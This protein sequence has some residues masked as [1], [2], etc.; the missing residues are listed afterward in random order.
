[1]NLV[2]DTIAAISTPPGEGGIGI[3]RLSG[4]QAIEWVEKIFKSTTGKKLSDKTR[5]VYYG[6]IWD[7]HECI[8]EVL[9][10]VMRA[11]HSYTAEDVVEIN[12][13]GGSGPLNAMLETVLKQG[14]RLANP[15]EF[16][17]RAFLNGRIDLIQAEAV[18][19]RIQARTRAGLKAAASSATGQLS[20]ALFD[21]KEQLL[22]AKSHIEAA[23][24]FPDQDLPDLITPE[25]QNKIAHTLNK[26]QT[27]YETADA[28]RLL[29]EG[30]RIVIAGKPNV[31][32]S[33]LFNA[34]LRDARAI[35]TSQAGTTRDLIEET[36]SI[37]GI[38]VRLLDT[39]GI[40]DTK[41]EIEKIGVGLART[42][43]EESAAV[44]FVLDASTVLTE[45]DEK[46]LNELNELEIPVLCVGNKID[47]GRQWEELPYAKQDSKLFW[48]SAGTLEGLDELEN[49][50]A[51]LLKGEQSMQ[52]DEPMLNRLHQKDS[53]RRAM[54]SIQ[55]LQKNYQESP[56]FMSIDIN[57]ALEALGEITGETTPDDV[58]EAIFNT[59]CIG[60]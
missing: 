42:A 52:G 56:E 13:H 19:D 34:L 7:D 5:Q 38:P 8:D 1:M 55:Q 32:K 40:R 53:L 26:M 59:F 41:D 17:Q 2:D 57:E 22:W 35:V 31:G 3:V 46:L 25:L 50:I 48:V 23:V 45:A 44:L 51:V 6:A 60:K 15:G 18:I 43:L 9:V 37:D 30:A 21:L 33:S 49:Q 36:I 16:T 14:A 11:P 54:E 20:H 12:G 39:A 58:L 47:L 29:R 24:D 27:L 28:G 4:D 10:H